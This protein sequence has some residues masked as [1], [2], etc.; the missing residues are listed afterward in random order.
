MRA[1]SFEDVMNISGGTSVCAGVTKL[2][3]GTVT[4][5]VADGLSGGAM[6]LATPVEFSF[7]A[8]VIGGFV[9]SAIC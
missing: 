4:A 5:G 6:T 1:L 2:I 9:A 8:D 7:G 3:A